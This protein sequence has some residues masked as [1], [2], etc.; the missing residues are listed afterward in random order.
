MQSDSRVVVPVQQAMAGAV[1]AI[2][3]HE[4]I[5]ENCSFFNS[6]H[7]SQGFCH[8]VDDFLIP[9]TDNPLIDPRENNLQD[10]SGAMEPQDPGRLFH[11]HQQIRAASG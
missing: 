9:I 10:H 2:V 4:C 8:Q 3:I 6:M 1:T 11:L 5:E 7:R